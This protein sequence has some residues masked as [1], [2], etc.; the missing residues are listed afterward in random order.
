MYLIAIVIELM[1][2]PHNSMLTLGHLLLSLLTIISAWFL[3]HT[4][5][6]IHYAHNYYLARQMSKMQDWISPRPNI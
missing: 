2:L 3:M 1:H 5:F 4:I 6:A